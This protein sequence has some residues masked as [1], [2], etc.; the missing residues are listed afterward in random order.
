[1]PITMPQKV[2]MTWE[3]RH[4]PFPPKGY[5][6][7]KRLSAGFCVLQRADDFMQKPQE[8]MAHA[9]HR[10]RKNPQRLR[11]APYRLG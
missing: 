10:L 5:D 9:P 3:R 4:P 11:S 8:C 2:M 1:M 6:A 7:L